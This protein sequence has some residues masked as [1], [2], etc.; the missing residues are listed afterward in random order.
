MEQVVGSTSIHLLAGM[1]AKI[2]APLDLLLGY[3][4]FVEDGEIYF[5]GEKT[6]PTNGFIVEYDDVGTIEPVPN[7][8]AIIYK[9]KKAEE[10]SV[11]FFAKTGEIAVCHILAV[12]IHD[13]SS[14]VQG[15][16]AY[17]TYF[18]DDEHET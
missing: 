16:P 11:W 8:P 9:H 5:K 18:S 10:N 4:W 7:E 12:P 2:E 14:V 6:S 13:H 17:G 3:G 1:Q 15:G